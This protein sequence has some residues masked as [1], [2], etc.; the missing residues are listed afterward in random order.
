[1]NTTL[2]GAIKTLISIPVGVI[3]LCLALAAPALIF[4]GSTFEESPATQSQV[5]RPGENSPN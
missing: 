2:I 4:F 3:G 1:L 5:A